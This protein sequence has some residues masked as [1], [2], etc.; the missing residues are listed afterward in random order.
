MS[1]VFRDLH[2]EVPLHHVVGPVVLHLGGVEL[3]LP[4]VD[5]AEVPRQP[6]LVVLAAHHVAA[7]PGR[8]GVMVTLYHVPLVPP[9]CRSP[10]CSPV[11]RT[12]KWSPWASPGYWMSRTSSSPAPLLLLPYTAEV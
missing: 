9:T 4:L 8:R 1:K 3:V 2:V 6:A 5:Q 11:Q 12:P 7:R 10:S